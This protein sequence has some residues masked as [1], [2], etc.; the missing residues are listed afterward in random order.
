[1]RNVAN[2]QTD[3]QT[4]N[5]ENISSLAEVITQV[6]DRPLSELIVSVSSWFDFASAADDNN[7][8][9]AVENYRRIRLR[10][11]RGRV[12][13]NGRPGTSLACVVY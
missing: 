9:V 13:A 1:M 6:A 12:S 8:N 3:R 10:Y 11:V 7:D 5:D 4:D 2:G